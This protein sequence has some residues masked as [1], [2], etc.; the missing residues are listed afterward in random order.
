[1]E[2]Y[3]I[4]EGE[5]EFSV[6]IVRKKVKNINLRV[7]RDMT[8]IVTA[9]K[10]I[11]RK[12]IFDFVH[13]KRDWILKHLHFFREQ[14][15]RI[16]AVK[17]KYKDEIL[18]L[19]GYCSVELKLRAG[20]KNGSIQGNQIVLFV[21]NKKNRGEYEKV[22]Q[23]WYRE[24][25]KQVF[26]ESLERL[27]PVVETF[28]VQFPTLTVRT[29][30]SRWGSCMVQKNQ[31]NLNLQL[32]K[33]PISCIDYVMLHELIH[34][35]Y[36]NHGTEFKSFLTKYMPDWKERKKQLNEMILSEER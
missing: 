35:L 19:G 24:Q 18:Y 28:G 3:V 8:V 30:K 9:D 4:G 21:R 23:M 29:M 5:Q 15:E 34:F 10:R 11:E 6:T 36:P 22:L 14:S 20:Q 32:I 26:S 25:A 17:N 2:H 12:R 16:Q 31:I 27:Y 13:E 7:Q 1:M 33:M